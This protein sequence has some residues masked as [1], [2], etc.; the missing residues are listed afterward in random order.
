MSRPAA[1]WTCSSTPS[2]RGAAC[3]N[4]VNQAFAGL[5]AAI[6]RAARRRPTR[7]G[8]SS[9]NRGVRESKLA[10]VLPLQAAQLPRACEW[11]RLAAA[12]LHTDC[13]ESV[14]HL[15]CVVGSSKPHRPAFP[16]VWTAA[17]ATVRSGSSIAF[18]ADRPE[19]GLGRQVRQWTLDPDTFPDK[20]QAPAEWRPSRHGLVD[21]SGGFSCALRLSRRSARGRSARIPRSTWSR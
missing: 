7:L 10:H 17:S 18:I 2:G 16:A 6:G 21:N 13:G 19:S 15:R 8:P 14:G 20:C 9:S 3:L 12:D 1:S 11:R 5:A 4:W